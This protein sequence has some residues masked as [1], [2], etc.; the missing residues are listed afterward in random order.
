MSDAARD[1]IRDGAPPSA[2]FREHESRLSASAGA[3]PTL[4]LACGRGRHALA[5]ADLGLCVVAIDRN[6]DFLDVLGRIRSRP[7]DGSTSQIEILCADLE[8]PPLPSLEPA[9]FGA[10]LVF[11]YL[12][13]PLFPWIQALVAP[14]GFVL[15]E[16]FTADQKKLGWG[17]R[18][19]AFL[20]KPGELPELFSELTIEVYEEGP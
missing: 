7:L 4:D 20:L 13:R 2:F 3:G 16:T 11:R 9:S 6:P 5:A 15:Y 14:G 10:V 18:R 19:D 12:H 8:S 17:P 1:E